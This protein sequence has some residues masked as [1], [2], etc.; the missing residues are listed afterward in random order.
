MEKTEL[1][2]QIFLIEDFLTAEACDKYIAMAEGKVFEE[3]QINVHGRQMMSKGIRN[4]DRLMIFDHDLAEDLFRIAEQFLPQEHE[5]YK[6][7]N[8]NEMFRIYKYTPGQRFKIHRDGSYI[9]NEHE[10]SFYTFMVYLNDDFEGGETE[11]ENLFTVAPKKGSA[12]VFYHPLR[13]E[14]KI[15]ISG[16]KYVLRTDVIYYNK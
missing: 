4:N 3:A 7:Q 2:P 6:L 16:K 14:G 8:F 5:N 11:F 1:H 10:K 15:L 12:M 9:R 13:H